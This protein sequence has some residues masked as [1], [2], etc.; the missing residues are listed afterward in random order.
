M[1]HRWSRDQPRQGSL[2]QTTREAE[3]RDPG[4]EVGVA[5]RFS[6]HVTKRNG[7]SGDENDSAQSRP[8]SPLSFWSAP[9]T[10]TPCFLVLTKRKADSEDEIGFSAEVMESSVKFVCFKT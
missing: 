5:L 1:C 7:G 4:N 8:Q 10:R 2:F 9:R 3:E 6:D